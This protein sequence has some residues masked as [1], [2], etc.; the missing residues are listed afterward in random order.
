[1]VSGASSDTSGYLKTLHGS[2]EHGIGLQG[3]CP[4]L[5]VA[6]GGTKD[7]DWDSCYALPCRLQTKE[8]SS[9]LNITTR[10]RSPCI[11][12]GHRPLAPTFQCEA[13]KLDWD[14]Y[15]LSLAAATQTKMSTGVSCYAFS[16]RA[17]ADEMLL[18]QWKS[19]MWE[20]SWTCCPGLLEEAPMHL[21]CWKEESCL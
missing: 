7:M 18:L 4:P 19:S 5:A 20:E 13:P 6:T 2:E 15:L 16:A 10:I 8:C 9:S 14:A 11:R 21:P 12:L 1:M 3:D 17:E